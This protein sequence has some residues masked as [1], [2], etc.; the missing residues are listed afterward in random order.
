MGRPSTTFVCCIES[1]PLEAMT[2][3]M[4]ESLRRFGGTLAQSP[5]LA[6]VSRMGP[7]IAGS[8]RRSLDR[9]NVKLVQ[10]PW[11]RRY[12]WYHFTN[13]PAAM[14]AVEE[15]ITTDQIVCLD[16][17]L[18]ILREPTELLLD[19]KTDFAACAPDLG[20]IGSTG[21]ASDYDIHWRHICST[22]GIS[23]DELPWIT[24]QLDRQRIRFYMNSGV[25]SYKRSSR[26]GSL[27]WNMCQKLLD[28]RCGFPGFGEHWI[29][30]MSLGLAIHANKLTWRE[31]PLS[32][33]HTM[34]RTSN[35][36]GVREAAILHYH[37]CMNPDFWPEML[38]RL[39][40][41]RPDVCDWLEPLG[42]VVSPASALS[43]YVSQGLRLGR[44]LPRKL[45]RQQM[46][47]PV[48]ARN[49]VS[50]DATYAAEG[51][52]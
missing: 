22:A 16:S 46:R 38:N 10:L 8:T 14:A 47:L 23:I 34:L 43:R 28:A 18:L 37:N 25:W 29:E 19:D 17:D 33:N 11:G 31:L 20:V 39:R 30:Q 48:A 7:S 15:T 2:V 45:Y 9:L 3:R 32:H 40:A 13:K 51:S 1:G 42:P 21:P 41:T 27:Y 5:V 35:T 49:D 44:G 4:V 36:T 50:V 6:V 52:T 26:V 12:A 24:T